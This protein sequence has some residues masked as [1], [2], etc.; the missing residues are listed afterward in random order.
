MASNQAIDTLETGTTGGTMRKSEQDS[1]EENMDFI[2]CFPEAQKLLQLVRDHA[3]SETPEL[4]VHPRRNSCCSLYVIMCCRSIR[5]WVTI[6]GNAADQE[7]SHS[8]SCRLGW[9][10]GPP[11]YCHY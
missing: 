11:Q 3:L 6:W 2:I 5:D 10:G 9:A 8:G 1:N 7:L 4:S